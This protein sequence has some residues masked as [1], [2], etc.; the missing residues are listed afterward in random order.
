MRRRRSPLGQANNS[1]YSEQTE[2]KTIACPFCA[3][4]VLAEAIKCK[5]CGEFIDPRFN[6]NV[7]DSSDS[8]QCG[9][10][11]VINDQTSYD[12]EFVAPRREMPASAWFGIASLI[13]GFV[14]ILFLF[15]PC[16]W[17]LALPVSGLA[18]ALGIVGFFLANRRGDKTSLPIWATVL[19]FL[20]FCVACGLNLWAQAQLGE[21]ASKIP[22][23]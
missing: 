6:P 22:D 16:F 20:L 19:C 15:L 5:H 13:G 18:M 23:M 9:H 14:G 7:I 2:S 3:E 17:F 21:A 12:P 11:E 8:V 4:T 1:L 10:G